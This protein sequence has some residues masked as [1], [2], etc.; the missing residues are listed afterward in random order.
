MV[1]LGF[2][3]DPKPNKRIRVLLD[4]LGFGFWVYK[5][6]AKALGVEELWRL[7]ELRIVGLEGLGGL[8]FRV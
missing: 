6:V 7:E 3:L 5:R 4:V 1:Y 2:C 8:G